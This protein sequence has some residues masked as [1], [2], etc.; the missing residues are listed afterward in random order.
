LHSDC[1]VCPSTV[2]L[3]KLYQ[4]RTNTRSDRVQFLTSHPHS[5]ATAFT[6]TCATVAVARECA[7]HGP[8]ASGG[9]APRPGRVVVAIPRSGVASTV[10][11]SVARWQAP[12]SRGRATAEPQCGRAVQV[13]T[14]LHEGEV[15]ATTDT[16]DILRSGAVREPPVTTSLRSCVLD[17]VFQRLPPPIRVMSFDYYVLRLPHTLFTLKTV[18]FY[19]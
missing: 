8:L 12:R 13:A 17:D 2:H 19:A 11:R 7:W 14:T 10:P 3:I 6:Q 5:R 15:R 18:R 4:V 1:T 9:V 16:N